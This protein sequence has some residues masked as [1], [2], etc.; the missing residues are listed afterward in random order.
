MRPNLPE[1]L[2]LGTGIEKRLER[3]YCHTERW[4]H[5]QLCFHH[6]GEVGRL[7]ADKSLLFLPQTFQRDHQRRAF[8][9][10]GRF[11]LAGRGRRFGRTLEWAVVDI[12]VQFRQT[13]ANYVPRKLD[14]AT[15]VSRPKA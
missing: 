4:R 13:G 7:A 1:L 8:G 15:Q 3:C 12:P 6:R 14:S 9:R 10:L 11:H 2:A 5:W